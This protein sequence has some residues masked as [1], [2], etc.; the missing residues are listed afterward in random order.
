MGVKWTSMDFVQIG[1]VVESVAPVIVWIGVKPDT[2]SGED[3]VA[4]AKE[5]KKLLVANDTFDVELEIRES[6]VWGSRA[7]SNDEA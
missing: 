1:V 4:A 6:V 5:C 2:I 3:G 7:G